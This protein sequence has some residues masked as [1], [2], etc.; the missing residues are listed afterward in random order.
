MIPTKRFS[1][2][3]LV[4]LSFLYDSDQTPELFLL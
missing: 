2:I 4:W 1:V 3:D